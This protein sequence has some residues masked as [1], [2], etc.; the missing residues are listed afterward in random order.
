MLI[1]NHADNILCK[2]CFMCLIS[3][4]RCKNANIYIDNS[5]DIRY[6]DDGYNIEYENENDV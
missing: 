6:Y 4:C 5:N 3:E 2:R 1:K